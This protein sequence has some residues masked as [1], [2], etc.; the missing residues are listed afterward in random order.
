MNAVI[1]RAA[2]MPAVHFGTENLGA[3]V[4]SGRAQRA[5]RGPAAAPP[6]EAS[7][8]VPVGFGSREPDVPVR[9]WHLGSGQTA[10]DRVRQT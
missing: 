4:L 7:A 3:H 6:D 2:G 1:A 5:R 10:G 8:A 9:R